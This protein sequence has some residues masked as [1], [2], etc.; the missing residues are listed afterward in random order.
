M[1]I[2]SNQIRNTYKHL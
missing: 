1:Q 2:Y